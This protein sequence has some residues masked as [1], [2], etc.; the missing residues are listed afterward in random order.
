MK[1]TTGKFRSFALK[2]AEHFEKNPVKDTIGL[3]VLIGLLVLILMV[4][5]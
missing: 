5:S 4:A 3:I 1:K 2:V